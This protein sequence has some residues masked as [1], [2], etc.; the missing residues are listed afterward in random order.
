MRRVVSGFVGLLAVA[1][2]GLVFG[3]REFRGE[4]SVLPVV[5]GALR[6]CGVEASS[7]TVRG[8]ETTACLQA[9]L[10]ELVVDGDVVALADAV[11]AV[12][13]REPNLNYQCHNFMHL[14]GS[15]LRPE[16]S[17][18]A[19]PALGGRWSA[20]GSGLVHGAFET[21]DLSGEDPVAAGELA[22]AACTR[23]DFAADR[24]LLADCAHSLGHSVYAAYAEKMSVGEKVCDGVGLVSSYLPS[25]SAVSQC[26]GGLYM[27]RA[28]TLTASIAVPPATVAGWESAFGFCGEAAD[29]FE[30]AVSFGRFASSDPGSAAAF[31]DWCADKSS[32]GRCLRRLAQ[33]LGTRT[34]LT[35]DRSYHDTCAAIADRFELDRSVC[36]DGLTS[37]WMIAAQ[38]GARDTVCALLNDYG[39][40]C[41]VVA[42]T[43]S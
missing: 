17:E 15:L 13:E 37:A 14:L 7:S 26:M 42:P 8:T 28:E 36:V 22:M 4:E 38:G 3:G 6:R 9:Q 35:G 27:N 41:R 25:G 33:D 12:Y 19:A 21:F 24:V 16:R 34:V 43:A 29:V 40:D 2:L 32:P 10:S 5:D 18:I 39:R 23:Q 30:C 11:L 31:A 1:L 20:C